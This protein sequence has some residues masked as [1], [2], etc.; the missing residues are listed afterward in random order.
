MTTPGRPLT[1][2]IIA[3]ILRHVRQE[4]AADLEAA[5]VAA[6]KRLKKAHELAMRAL[7]ADLKGLGSTGLSSTII[8]RVAAGV[9]EA[10]DGMDDDI[11][12]EGRQ[13]QREGARA[14][15]TVAERVFD[16]LKI[17]RYAQPNAEGLLALI[18]IVDT[19]A[20]ER[21]ARGFGK[22]H[23][24]IVA[25]QLI[26]AAGEGK[27]GRAAELAAR[28]YLQ[29]TAYYDAVRMVRTTQVV[30]ARRGLHEIYRQNQGIVKGWVWVSAKDKRTCPSCWAMDGT[31][32]GLDEE[33]NDHPAGRCAPAPITEGYDD[34]RFKGGEEIFRELPRADQ[35][36]ILGGGRWLA[37]RAGTF[38]F[39]QLSQTFTHPVFGTMRHERSLRELV[40]DEM[41]AEFIEDARRG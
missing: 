30:A 28:Q 8:E 10:L 41:A 35:E 13:A 33:L 24:Q 26:R 17:A 22:A 7:E 18:D 40:G 23:G 3:S 38:R 20:Y 5:S 11:L 14:A 32:H 19:P 27:P 36:D 9:E 37:W 21:W 12:D 4:M 29:R 6:A 31:R 15:R 39:D 16:A 34:M 1:P 2:D 25:A